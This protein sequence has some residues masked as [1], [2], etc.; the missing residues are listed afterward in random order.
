MSATLDRPVRSI[1]RRPTATRG[2]WGWAVT[3]AAGAVVALVATF[4]RAFEPS[5][6]HSGR[7]PQ[8]IEERSSRP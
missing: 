8:P 7:P 2:L 6:E 4:G 1:A 5:I 3:P